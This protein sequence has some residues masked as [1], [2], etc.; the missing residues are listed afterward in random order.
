MLGAAKVAGPGRVALA[1]LLLSFK[2]SILVP[3]KDR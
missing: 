2:E 1:A 3:L